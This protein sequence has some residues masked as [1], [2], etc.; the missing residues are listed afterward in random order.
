MEESDVRARQYLVYDN[1]PPY[2]DSWW[3]SETGFIVKWVVVSVIFFVF[4]VWIIGGYYH[5]RRRI[6]QGL[7]PMG[8]HRWLVP[9]HQRY[10]TVPVNSYAYYTSRPDGYGGGGPAFGT[11]N[12]PPPVYGGEMPPTYQPPPPGG[13]KTMPAE[14]YAAPVTRRPGEEGVQPPREAHTQ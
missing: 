14:E 2:Y 1:G 6:R 11:Y 13:S 12:E 4:F 7:K 10:S 3:F 9:A 5:A 8:Y